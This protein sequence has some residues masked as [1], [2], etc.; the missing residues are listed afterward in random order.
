MIV[1]GTGHRPDKLGGY[2]KEANQRLIHLAEYWLKSARPK[3]V[4]SGMALGWDQALAQAAV[5]VGIPFHAYI[6]FEGQESKWPEESRKAY[7]R[8]MYKAECWNE[9]SPPGY[10]VWK[11][12]VRN[13]SMVND[14]DVVL[15]LWNGSDG[16]TANCVAYAKKQGKRIVNLWPVYKMIDSVQL[17]STK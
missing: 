17:A 1:C 14:A 10:A 5:N 13:E 15:A 4:I 8:L 11:M 2:T 7:T 9:C 6:P 16:G 3:I 12:Q